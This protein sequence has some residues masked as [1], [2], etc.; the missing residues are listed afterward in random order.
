MPLLCE[1]ST[2]LVPE[3]SGICFGKSKDLSPAHFGSMEQ[4]KSVQREGA[5]QRSPGRGLRLREKLSSAECFLPHLWS[6]KSLMRLNPSKLAFP[7]RKSLTPW[8]R[9]GSQHLCAVT[10][11]NCPCMGVSYFQDLYHDLCLACAQVRKQFSNSSFRKCL[12]RRIRIK[13]TF[14][15]RKISMYFIFVCSQQFDNFLTREILVLKVDLKGLLEA[16]AA[17]V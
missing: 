6:G 5:L 12:K 13:A 17:A 10:Y 16:R 14:Q 4:Q 11:R 9:L 7:Q 1:Q 2:R 8:R 15:L 3:K